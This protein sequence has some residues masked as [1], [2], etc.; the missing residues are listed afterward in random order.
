MDPHF[1][2]RRPLRHVLIST[3]PL[4][5]RY[6]VQ[7]TVGKETHDKLRRLQALL[8]REIPN[9][10]PAAIFDR[11]VTLL[12]EKVERAKTGAAARPRPIRPGTDKNRSRH[13][14]N[15][16]R[17]VAWR[18]DDGQCGF[19]APDGQRCGERAFLE[20]HHLDAYALGGASTPE[21]IA[22]RCRRHNQY[23]A[24]RVFGPRHAPN[25]IVVS[26]HPPDGEAKNHAIV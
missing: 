3:A 12:L 15:E 17:R 24:E 25:P 13:T 7:F 14:P 20:Y 18:R 11:A 19:V 26:P 16:S 23:E 22:L 1:Q 8:R 2:A 9:G 10:D 21:N 5:Q 4:A 6:R